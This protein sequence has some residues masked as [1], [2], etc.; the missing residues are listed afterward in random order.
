MND[1]MIA[2]WGLWVAVVAAVAAIVAA[3]AAIWTL[4]YAK[5]AP[6]KDDLSRVEENTAHL[7]EVRTGI[8]SV[9][10]RLKKQEDAESIRIRANR[11]SIT[12]SGNLAGTVPYPLHLLI[13]EPNPP[14]LSLTHIE[15]YNEHGNSFGSFPCSRIGDPSLLNF[16]ADIPMTAM[17]EWFRAGT[18]VQT[19]SRVRLKLRVWM[20]MDGFEAYR[21]MAVTIVDTS[22]TGGMAGFILNGSV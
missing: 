18:P 10:S 8:S 7:E 4:I 6:T 5:D 16:Q 22:N 2:V 9:D 13:R 3:V 11:V 20:S 12:A 19:L 14:N 1:H 21:D 15:L 17:G